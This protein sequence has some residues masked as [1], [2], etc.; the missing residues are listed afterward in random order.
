[1]ADRF[2]RTASDDH[3]RE[4]LLRKTED[5]TDWT[6]PNVLDERVLEAALTAWESH[7]PDPDKTMRENLLDAMRSALAVRDQEGI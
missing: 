7:K 5:G 2:Y 3:D 4:F 1:M 6:A